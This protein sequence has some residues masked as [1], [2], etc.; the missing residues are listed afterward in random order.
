MI[1][2]I[3]G[4]KGGTGK[5]TIATNLAVLRAGKQGRDVLLVDTD[6]QRSAASWLQIRE[7]EELTPKISCVQLTGK[8]SVLSEVR[9]LAPRYDDVIIDA[10]GRDSFELRESMILARVMLIPTQPSQF[11]IHS[12]ATMD[13]MVSEARTVNPDLAAYVLINRAPVHPGMSDTDDAREF[14]AD[15]QNLQLTR[16]VIRDRASFRRAA[17]LGKAVHEMERQDEKAVLEIRHLFKEAFQITKEV[18]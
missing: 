17:A 7:E 11:D 8:G 5:T 9:K 10:G 12:L 1:V 16:A 13:R 4:E 14:V 15:M 3:G 18:A 6:T 2:L